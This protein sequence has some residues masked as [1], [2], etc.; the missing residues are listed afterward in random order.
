MLGVTKSLAQ[1]LGYRLLSE[2]P[3][4]VLPAK[5]VSA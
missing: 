4:K 1:A 5:T 2:T 3:I